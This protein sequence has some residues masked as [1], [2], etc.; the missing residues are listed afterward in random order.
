LLS[1]KLLSL[2]SLLPL[3]SL[4][5]TYTSSKDKDNAFSELLSLSSLILSV[6]FSTSFIEFAIEAE[7]Y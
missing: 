7:Y 2:P 1:S 3:S 4:I 6:I 5:E